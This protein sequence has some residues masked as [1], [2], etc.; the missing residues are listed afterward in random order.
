MHDRKYEII[1]AVF[2]VLGAAMLA[3]NGPHAGYGFV[4][5]LASNAGWLIF[6]YARRHWFLLIQTIAYTITSVYGVLKWLT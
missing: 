1:G 6:S 2:G 4:A 3:H 5:Y